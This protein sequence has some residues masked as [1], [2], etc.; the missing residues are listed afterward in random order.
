MHIRIGDGI[1]WRASLEIYKKLDI[2]TH[3]NI[4]DIIIFCGSHN[5][6]GPAPKETTNYLKDISN[7]LSNRGYNVIIRSANS[8]DDDFFLMVRAKYFIPGGMCNKI[9]PGGGG[10]NGL[11]KFTR[12][13]KNIIS[14]T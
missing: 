11:V 12:Y 13:F 3:T 5:C 10:Y 8:P 4:K 1:T 6:K 7:I 9:K 14:N 2:E